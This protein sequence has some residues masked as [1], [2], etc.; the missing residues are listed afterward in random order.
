M[1][2]RPKQRTHT[3]ARPRVTLALGVSLLA[4]AVLLVAA[5]AHLL[6]LTPL[7]SLILSLGTALGLVAVVRATAPAGPSALLDRETRRHSR[8][9]E[10]QALLDIERAHTAAERRLRLAREFRRIAAEALAAPPTDRRRWPRAGRLAALCRQASL[11]RA[12]ATDRAVAF[13]PEPLPEDR[14]S[15]EMLAEAI[16]TL[17]GYL[18]LLSAVRRAPGWD[19]EVQ[20]VIVRERTRLE[21]AVDRVSS[22]LRDA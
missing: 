13:L 16:A 15:A 2:Q 21:V 6:D 3:P 22:V 12:S 7:L 5:I 18:A 9:G 11:L 8:P 14:L 19:L 10:W 17:T 4:G 20:R 1:H